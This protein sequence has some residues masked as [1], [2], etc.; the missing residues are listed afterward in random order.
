MNNSENNFILKL[1][2]INLRFGGVHAVRDININIV[3]KNITGIIG[4]NGAGKTTL[5][6]IISGIYKPDKGRIIYKD[7]DITKLPPH[8]ISRLGIART[9]QNL[10]LLARS[11][12]LDNIITAAQNKFYNYN[13]I[14]NMLHV[15]R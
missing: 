10:R 8:K 5:F 13:F 1:I 3:N 4:P 6:N 7:Q 14:E 11:S 12:V 15:G 2:N 9:F